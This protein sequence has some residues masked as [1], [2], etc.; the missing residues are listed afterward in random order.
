MIK[1]KMTIQ[2][3]VDCIEQILEQAYKD[4][5]KDYSAVMNAASNLWSLLRWDISIKSSFD[6]ALLH[7]KKSD[8]PFD[9]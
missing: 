8:E 6:K 1:E 2:E 3:M 9:F 4:P 7:P 5:S